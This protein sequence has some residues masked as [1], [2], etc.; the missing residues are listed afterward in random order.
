MDNF[1]E[2]FS[3]IAGSRQCHTVIIDCSADAKVPLQYS[4]WLG[5]GIH[6][7]TPNKK[8]CSGP[9]ADWSAVREATQLHGTQFMYEVFAYDHAAFS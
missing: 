5:L 2:F 8:L 4:K 7:V 1:T 3:G 6:V 9:M